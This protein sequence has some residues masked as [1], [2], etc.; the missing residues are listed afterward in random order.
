VFF[1]PYPPAQRGSASLHLLNPAPQRGE[2]RLCLLQ[3]GWGRKLEVRPLRV[4]WVGSR[5][6]VSFRWRGAKDAIEKGNTEEL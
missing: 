5:T 3:L 1:F 6:N 4:G 2:I